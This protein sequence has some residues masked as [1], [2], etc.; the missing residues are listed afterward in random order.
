MPP[1]VANNARIG[2]VVPGR[3]L[4][5]DYMPGRH[6]IVK[7]GHG[8]GLSQRQRPQYSSRFPYMSE[9]CGFKET[10]V[11]R[12][13]H[14]LHGI[15]VQEAGGA[16]GSSIQSKV[17]TTRTTIWVKQAAYITATRYRSRGC[18][19][20]SLIPSVLACFMCI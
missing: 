14:T 18:V 3:C 10:M 13:G 2:D 12:A 7:G 5:F 16:A 1:I 6:V 15:W 11:L 8:Q 20:N 9:V 4:I 19:G 17:Y